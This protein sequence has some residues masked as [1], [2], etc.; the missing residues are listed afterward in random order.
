MPPKKKQQNEKEPAGK[1]P[2]NSLNDLEAKE[3]IAETVSVWT[4]RGLGQNHK[5]AQIEKLHPAPFSYQ[6]VSRLIRFFSKPGETVLDPFAGVASTLKAAAIEGRKGIGIELEPKFA[7]LARKRLNTELPDDESVCREQKII[8]GDVFTVLPRLES[9]SVKV[10]VTSPPYWKILHKQD[11][12]VKQERVS[13]GLDY[14]YSESTKDLG[15]IPVYED[16]ID[17][18]SSAFGLCHPLLV[19]G[20]HLC[21]VVG[22]FREKAKYH[23][24]HA[25]LANSLEQRGFALKGI[26]ILYQRHK[27]IFPYGYPYAYVPN[28]HHQYI[29]ILRKDG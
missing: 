29:L 7:Q 1:K 12:K 2:V 16:F 9:E 24:L 27:R 22:D 25:D 3:W 13:K 6:D 11:H 10:V 19:K 8:T 17:R 23:M 18:L 21:I 5:D 15:N 4:Q 26:T 14:K 20:G 28:M